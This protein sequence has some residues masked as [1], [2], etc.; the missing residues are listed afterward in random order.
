MI[1]AEP[2]DAVVV[3]AG[4]AGSLFAARLSG[5]GRR[6]TLLEAGPAWRLGDLVSS[7][8]WARR[9]KWGG[10]PVA[11]AAQP[12]SFPHNLN[13]GWGLGGAALHHYATWPRLPEAAH[14][15]QSRFGKGQDWPFGA[16]ALRPWYDRVQADVGLSGD[17]AREP[18]RPPGAPYPQKPLRQF[19]QGALLQRGF[20]AAGLPVAPLPAAILT[21]WKGER[22][23]CQHDGWC[24]AGCPIGALANPLVTHLREAEALGAT[25]RAGAT[26]VRV[27]P[28]GAGRAA[29][30]LWADGEGRLHEQ[31][32]AVVILAVSAI[33]TPRLLLAS[34][35]PEWPQ[36]A[37]N[38]RGLVGRGLMVEAV[39][40]AAG[41]FDRPTECH[42][43]VSA[44]QLMHR[45][46][47]GDGRDRP[48]GGYQWQIGPSLKPS[49]IFGMAATRPLL[50]G[51]AL[52]GFLAD[53]SR[54]MATM[55]G[56]AEQLPD[57]ANRVELD[58]RR[59]RF[60]VPL[61][62]IVHAHDAGTRA[63]QAHLAAEGEAIVRAAGAREA[64]SSPLGGGHPAGGTP[65]GDD[66]ERS[67][68][69]AFGRVHGIPNLFVT[70]SGLFPTTAGT[71]PTFTLMALAE[72]AAAELLDHWGDHAGG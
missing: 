69:D 49:D 34:A 36:G 61:A 43:G 2:V 32:A 23:P 44:G 11:H 72:R 57:P 39:A 4:A 15:M 20:E 68:T 9:L 27:L 22:A 21:D 7:P 26:V 5:A 59:D 33:Q 71:S 8:I 63:L 38:G 25:I 54:H 40:Q 48:F 35:A 45:A 17:A 60:G 14:A 64:W 47:P 62:R 13:M 50:H 66:P 10:P 51:P 28:R 6:V 56:M 53:A 30:V 55:V 65:M 16:E 46:V 58:G 37:G 18:W 19:A 29:G 12:P 70:G 3:G 31:P 52:H 24:D 42:M 67:V 1:R 41:L